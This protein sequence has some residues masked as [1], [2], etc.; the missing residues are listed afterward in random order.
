MPKVA[1]THETI[2]VETKG[3]VGIIA[4]NRPKAMN[5][6]NTQVI[7]EMNGALT[8]FDADGDIG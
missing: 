2:I 7:R 3:A 1:M 5:A 6:L 8:A 4:F